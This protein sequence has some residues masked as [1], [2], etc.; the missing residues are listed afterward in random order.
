MPN[1]WYIER[2]IA[3]PDGKYPPQES[4]YTDIFEYVEVLEKMRDKQ[5]D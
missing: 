3:T 2:R 5:N 4:L 1:S